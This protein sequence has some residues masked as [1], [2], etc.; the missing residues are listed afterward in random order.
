MGYTDA[1]VRFLRSQRLG[2]IAT[3]SGAG[4]PDVAPVGFELAG[5]E[6][7]IGGMDISRTRK[8]LNVKATERAAFVVD[9]LVSV[10]PWQPRGL[11]VVGQAR[12][13]GTE[14]GG[15]I[16]IAPQTVWSWGIND[17]AERHH[18]MT[19]KRPF[20]GGPTDDPS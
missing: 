6:I 5:D 2:R 16:R 7:A 18:G 20:G 11:K 1:E 15:S 10:E 13:E 14:A 12:I 8:Y 4:E 19:E 3:V 17:D 9:E